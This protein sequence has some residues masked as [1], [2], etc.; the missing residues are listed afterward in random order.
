MG[1]EA[2]AAVQLLDEVVEF[3]VQALMPWTRMLSHP[4]EQDELF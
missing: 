2:V 1:E 4:Y 3:L